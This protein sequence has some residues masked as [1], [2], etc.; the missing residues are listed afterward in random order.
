MGGLTGNSKVLS[1]LGGVIEACL[2][3]DGQEDTKPVHR[4]HYCE[5][6]TSMQPRLGILD[7]EHEILLGVM[8]LAT[9]IGLCQFGASSHD[10]SVFC[11][12]EI[13]GLIVLW[14]QPE[15]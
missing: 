9:I 13:R 10:D 2:E 12:E 14:D 7:C 6:N 5:L 11:V 4:R 8:A 3:D 15:A 1:L